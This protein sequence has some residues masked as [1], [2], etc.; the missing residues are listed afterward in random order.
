VMTTCS[1]CGT[2]NQEG[3]HRC[4]RCGRK[5]DDTL[6]GEFTLPHNVGAL[7]AQPVFE[8]HAG[9]S[10]ARIAKPSPNLSRAVQRSL[11]QDKTAAKVVPIGPT[12]R[13]APEPAE[14]PVQRTVRRRPRVAEGQEKLDFLPPAAPKP[15]TLGT[16]VEAMIFCEERVAAAAHRALAAMLDWS[17]VLIAYG[18]FLGVFLYCAGGLPLNKTNL[19][20]MGA[21]LPLFGI[22]YGLVWALAGAETA[23]MSWTRLR[24]T[25]FEGFRPER[26]ER[27]MRFAGSCLS[28]CTIVGLLWSLADEEG[29]GWQDHISRTFPTPRRADSQVFLRR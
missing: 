2:R 15:R 17:M 6:N 20:V 8:P 27:L 23:G 3:E 16:E 28:L 7:A 12:P 11:F 29:L 26:K 25:T 24:L 21:V 19:A 18:V 5:P 10:Q 14:K 9:E 13:R 4:R 22:V 1:Y